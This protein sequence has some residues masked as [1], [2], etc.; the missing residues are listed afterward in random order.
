MNMMRHNM[1]WLA[2]N[3]KNMHL[4]CLPIWLLLLDLQRRG[5]NNSAAQL[6][7]EHLVPL[8]CG[9]GRCRFVLRGNQTSYT[10]T[11]NMSSPL[12]PLIYETRLGLGSVHEMTFVS[13]P[14]GRLLHM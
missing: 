4:I 9:V 6:V 12:H 8:A 10:N 11:P 3:V 14:P 5:S 2:C 13:N 1:R 7:Q